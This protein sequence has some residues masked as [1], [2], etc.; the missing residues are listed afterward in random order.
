MDAD[1]PNAGDAP[2][3]GVGDT[4]TWTYKVTN[5]GDTNLWDVR[6][7]DDQ[8]GNVSCPLPALSPN[9]WMLCEAGRLATTVGTHSRSA[10]DRKHRWKPMDYLPSAQSL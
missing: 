6:V 1:D 10:A 9:E 5:T 2:Q 7:T 8:I 3:I 4:V